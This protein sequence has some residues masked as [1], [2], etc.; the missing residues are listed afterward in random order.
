MLDVLSCYEDIVNIFPVFLGFLFWVAVFRVLQP[1][2]YNFTL[3][4]LIPLPHCFALLFALADLPPDPLRCADPVWGTLSAVS[5]FFSHCF[6]SL[7]RG[8][9]WGLGI[10]SFSHF[11]V[12]WANSRV[13]L[14]KIIFLG[15]V[16][17]LT[18]EHL[19]FLIVILFIYLISGGAGFHCC[20]RRLFSSCCEWGSS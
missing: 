4:A 7:L 10:S 18:W 2:S 12:V 11:C 17:L 6:V 15:Y 16:D 13:R 8:G 5:S 3:A 9:G 19:F 14:G 20:A 1:G